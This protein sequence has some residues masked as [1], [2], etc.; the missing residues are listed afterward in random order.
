MLTGLE[1]AA[2][3]PLP[4]VRAEPGLARTTLEPRE[5]LD[6]A[7]RRA[8]ERSPC[9]VSFSGGCDSS[10]VLAAAVRVA[11]REGLP[12]PVPVTMVSRGEPAAEER[13]WQEEVVRYLGVDAWER[14]EV[15][16]ELDC[17]GPVARPLLL[18]HGV[19]WPPNAHFHVLQLQLAPGGSLLTGIGGDE[20]FS[21]SSWARL[22][23]VLAVRA[24]PVPRDALRLAAAAAPSPVRRRVATARGGPELPWLRPEAQ[25]QV[26]RALAREAAD[27]PVRWRAR[28]AWLL[29]QRYVS[30]GVQGLEELAREH[31]VAIHHPLLDRGLAAALASLPRS[32]RFEDRPQALTSLFGDLLPPAVASR[33]SKASF[34]GVLWGPESEAFARRWNG[35]GVDPEIVD[36]DALGRRWHD[37]RQPGPHTLLQSLWLAEAHQTA[38]SAS[39]RRSSVPGSASQER[40]LRSSHAGSA[41]S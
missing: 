18:R 36:V 4:S 39:S 31:G 6:R 3:V 12:A 1:I 40:G 34:A 23:S 8:L 29:S 5:A 32:R 37:E 13:A 17:V 7:V 35:E 14:V 41:L 38:P 22:R 9:L 11:R 30:L 27:E 16:E 2:G 24:V 19:L 15:G 25:G 28:F 26:T 20:L 33:R 10:L 21:R